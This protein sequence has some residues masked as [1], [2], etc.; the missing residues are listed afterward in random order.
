MVFLGLVRTDRQNASTR[1]KRR[2][3]AQDVRVVRVTC[4]VTPALC[5]SGAESEW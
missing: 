1:E 4:R 2:E 5:G 3:D